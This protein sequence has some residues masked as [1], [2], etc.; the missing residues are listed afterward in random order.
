MGSRVVVRYLSVME[1][2]PLPNN[3]GGVTAP[4]PPLTTPLFHLR[5]PSYHVIFDI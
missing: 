3:E 1:P 4:H 5:I 2:I